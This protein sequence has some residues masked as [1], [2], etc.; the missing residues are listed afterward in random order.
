MK[1]TITYRKKIAVGLLILMSTNLLI[2]PVCLALTSGPAQP[3]TQS[4]QPAGVSDMVDPFTGGFKYNIPLLDIDGYPINLSYESGT[5]MDDEAS[6]V[7]LGWNVN[8]GA[9]NRQLRGVPDDMSGDLEQIDHYTKPKVTVGGRLSAKIEVFG[10]GSN[11]VP[12]FNGSFS[13]GIFNDNYTG[14]GA[15]VGINAG[16]SLSKIGDSPFTAGLGLG[17]TS[18]TASGVDVTPSMNLGISEKMTSDQT[19]SAGLSA[20]LGYNSRSGLKSLT[21]GSSFDVSRPLKDKNGEVVTD[22]KGNVETQTD[23]IMGG[24][25]SAIS[26][27]TEPIMPRIQVPYKTTY[28]SFSVDAGGVIESVFLGGGMTGY[29]S[30]N[31]VATEKFSNPTYGFLYAEQG[32]NQKNAVMDFI[33]ENE[34]PIIPEIPNLALPVGTPDIFSFTSQTGSGQFRL[35][36]GGSGAFFDNQV[37]NG[38]SST[39]VGA[40]LGCCF[41][42]HG[43]V[44]FYNQNGTNTTRKWV[45]NNNYLGNG[46][47]QDISYTNPNS[48]QAYF[49][50]VGEKTAEDANMVAALHDVQPLEVSISGQTAN[51]QFTNNTLTKLQKLNRSINNTQISYL[52]AQ[53]ASLAGLDK[54]INSYPFNN[55]ANFQVPANNKPVADTLRPRYDNNYHQKHHISEITVTGASGKRM[56]YGLPVY[57]VQQSEYSF[58]IGSKNTDYTIQT[59]TNNIVPLA[60]TNPN[61]PQAAI[62]HTKGID[63]Y[64]HVQSHPAYASSFLLTAILSPDYVDKTGDGIT[65]DDAGTAIKF[66]YSKL[67]NLF[68]WRTPYSGATLNRSLLADKD[69][70]KGSIVYGQKELWYIHSIESKTKVA[71]FVTQNRN[72]ALGVTDFTGTKMDTTNRQKCLTE[73]LLYSKAD[74][75]KP[76]KVVKFVYDYELCRGVPNNSDNINGLNSNATLGGKLTLKKVYFEYANSPKGANYPY[77]FTYQNSVNNVP[78]NYGDL[79][80]DRWGTYKSTTENLL[81]LK[82]DEFP[83]TNQDVQGNNP[84]VKQRIDQNAALWHLSSVQLPTGGLINITYESN[85]YAYVQDKRAMVMSGISAL[86]DGSGNDLDS[87][88][89]N[90]LFKAKGIRLQVPNSA[91][92]GDPTAWFEQTYLNNSNYLYTKF[93]DKVSTPNSYNGGTD[94][95]YDFIPCYAQIK[96][97]SF[98]GGYAKIIFVDRT[99]G[100][101]TANPIIFSAWQNLKDQY[102]RYAYPGF[103]TRTKDSETSSAVTSAVKAIF[104]AIGNLKELTESFYQKAA[105]NNYGSKIHLNS[106]FVKVVKQDGFKLGGGV[107]VK[108]IQ[109]SDNWQTMSQNGSSATANYG[110]AYTYTTVDNGVTISSG[111]ASYEPSIGNDENPLKLPVPYVEKIKGSVDSFFDL[112]Q[113]FGESFFPAP[114]VGYS[115]VTITDLDKNGNPD[116][117]LR[118][119]YSVDEFYT[120][121]DFPVQVT[122][123]PISENE[124]KPFNKF[125]FLGA[126]NIDELTMSQGYAITVNDM[127]G[128]PKATRTLNQAGAEIASTVYYYNTTP[129]GADEYQLANTVNIVNPDGSVSPNQV[130]GRDIDFFTDFREFETKN[131]GR[132][133]DLGL[134]WISAW[135]FNFPLPHFPTY[136]NSDYKLFRSACAVKLNQYYGV[137]DKVVKT[138]NGSSITT[139]NVAFD[140]LTG[141]PI[142][143]S[144]QNEFDNKIYSVNIPAYWIYNGMGP[145]YQNSGILLKNFSTDVNGRFV[146]Y[147]TFLKSGD[148]IVDLTTGNKYWVINDQSPTETGPTNKLINMAGQL[149]ASFTATGTVKLVQ[150]GYRNI[151]DAGATSLVCL[152]NPIQGNQLKVVASSDLTGYKVINASA[153][154][155]NESWPMSSTNGNADSVKVANPVADFT[156]ATALPAGNH[157]LYGAYI[158]NAGTDTGVVVQNAFLQGG[159]NRSGVWPNPPTTLYLNAP[160]GFQKTITIATSQTYYI[161]YSG[162]DTYSYTID[163]VALPSNKNNQ[164]WSVYPLYLSAGT[165]VINFTATNVPLPGGGDS[166]STNPGAIGMEI[167]NCTASQLNSGNSLN[168][169]FSTT[170]VIGDNTLQSFLTINGVR[171]NHYIYVKVINP[172]I[173]GYLGNWRERASM[174][175]QQSRYINPDIPANGLN[176]KNAGYINNFSAFWYY[177]PL[178]NGGQGWQTDQ[179]GNRARWV[180]A[181]TVTSYDLYG[182]Q[183]ENVDALGRFSAAKFDFNGELPG[184]VASNSMSREMYVT[185]FEDSYFNPGTVAGN[186]PINDFKETSTGAPLSQFIV[187]TTSH[188][189]NYSLKL[190]SDGITLKTNIYSQALRIDSL[191]YIYNTGEYNVKNQLGL[192]PN[193]FE[194]N[195]YKKYI[196]DTWVYDGSP[197][198][199]S[200]KLT[201][202]ENGTSVPLTCK[203]NVEGW[204]LLEGTI[205]LTTVAPGTLNIAVVPSNGVTLYMDDIRIHPFDALLKSYVYD[206]K[207]MRLMAELDENCFATFYEYD[208]EGLLIRVKKETERGVMTIKESRSSYRKYTGL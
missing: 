9:V 191:L 200:V 87:T 158:Y 199:K 188:S 203:A 28:G 27:N 131:S 156:Y 50:V 8:V 32:K 78:I 40:D 84:S 189:G 134:D 119:G 69:D 180:T 142:V 103:D 110:Q 136:N 97:V 45:S 194:P 88:A 93:F 33:R 34:N 22:S 138:Q 23:Q 121:K 36:R 92:T 44:T 106:C 183:L 133:I 155:Y 146:N 42:F 58:A 126:T 25:G 90:Y 151:L 153:K 89:T 31:E 49:K 120:A 175:F 95:D 165:H 82:N 54:T 197:G 159:L 13:L 83:Y 202:T 169:V 179:N 74:M 143:T 125:S 7:G 166:P 127:H 52:T 132:S 10:H 62:N 76:I 39:T 102:P 139:Q 38:N 26:F 65:D 171:V 57:N 148:E 123:L 51:A 160:V 124:N 100:G 53:E 59:G 81:P 192:Y 46:D 190:P 109:I 130:I 172:Y 71:Y 98:S 205:D 208:D 48:Q 181:N 70:D 11:L 55:A 73:I 168:T 108:K 111:V 201:L 61:T 193:G 75:S 113:P 206:D 107:R 117:T 12:N 147:N 64:Y 67:P 63:N 18:S 43:G 157:G 135:I 162:D 68:K 163:N 56:V 85:D 6:W 204:K 186:I 96:S 154:T 185:G 2:P 184:G 196:F 174:V 149:A 207:T 101:E 5:G 144:T 195:P 60:L 182:Q 128:K 15:D 115:K 66:N 29:K 137:I 77:E 47:F 4:F 141:E 79:E 176:I 99:D 122:V 167:Y 37:T 129:L 86:I 198:D 170:G 152:T 1:L 3:E 187:N 173:A 140:G 41:I 161:G 150:S 30:V 178:T 14:I 91:V 116:P 118:T 21:L 24:S 80:T 104:S 105:R 112:E 114:L 16:I 145:A 164:Y 72:D 20:S 19:V 35:H 17:I 177:G 94:Y